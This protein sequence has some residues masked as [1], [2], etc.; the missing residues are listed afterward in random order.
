MRSGDVPAFSLGE[1]R[2]RRLEVGIKAAA[3]QERAVEGEA[4]DH[5][6]R[7][8]HALADPTRM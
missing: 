2:A 6:H 3:K 5:R 1:E 8:T 4:P 7:H